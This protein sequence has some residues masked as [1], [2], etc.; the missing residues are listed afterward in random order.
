[1]NEDILLAAT[2]AL[3]HEASTGTDAARFTRARVM[4]SV[5]KRARRRG[6]RLAFLLPIAAVLVGST[7]WGTASG[8]LP[9]SWQQASIAVGL[10]TPPVSGELARST[11]WRTSLARL[12]AAPV[13][14]PAV[15]V[16]DDGDPT[17]DP[18]RAAKPSRAAMAAKPERS[19][20][21]RAAPSERAT[22]DPADNL[23]R[24]AHRRHFV[25][26]DA[27]GAVAAW[28][29]YLAAAPRGRFTLEARYNRA[30]CLVRLG[31]R[32]EAQAALEPFAAGRFGGYRQRDA[33]E[34]SEALGAAK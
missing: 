20:P 30:L 3:R 22:P 15:A 11:T 29:A 4:A 14:G 6:T 32:A 19:S 27:A 17:E 31:R 2:R 8:R 33:S 1:M 26:N 18:S 7:A 12:A 21:A 13:V 5:H 23:Y 24:V 10:T 28:D 25:D 16:N 34:L 9:S